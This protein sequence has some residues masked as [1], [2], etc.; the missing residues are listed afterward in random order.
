MFGYNC[1][2]AQCQNDLTG[3]KLLE[4]DH[5]SVIEFLSF[6][7]YLSDQEYWTG[8]V[9]QGSTITASTSGQVLGATR[10]ALSTLGDCVY[11]TD[12]S[13]KFPAP[14]LTNGDCK[15]VKKYICQ[16]YV[17][18]PCAGVLPGA[19]FSQGHC[20]QLNNVLMYWSQAQFT[21][22]TI[23]WNETTNVLKVSQPSL[24]INLNK[25]I[26]MLQ[27]IT[28]MAV[29]VGQ[30]SG[31]G[32][33]QDSVMLNDI[34]LG[35][36]DS[37]HEGNFTWMSDDRPVSIDDW[38]MGEPNDYSTFN[39]EDNVAWRVYE[40]KIQ[41]NDMNGTRSQARALCQKNAMTVTY[42]IVVPDS[43]STSLMTRNQI[44]ITSGEQRVTYLRVTQRFSNETDDV[45]TYD[46]VTSYRQATYSVDN[47]LQMA[48]LSGVFRTLVLL[49][50]TKHVTVMVYFRS[51]NHVASS[52]VFPVQASA[53]GFFVMNP[54]TPSTGNRLTVT[55]LNDDTEVK[56]RFPRN[57]TRPFTVVV[58]ELIFQQ[59]RSL[60]LTL[61]SLQSVQLISDEDF[62]GT[63][64][65]STKSVAVYLGN[66]NSHSISLDSNVDMAIPVDSLTSQYVSFP[67][68]PPLGP[69]QLAKYRF[70]C[71]YDNTNITIYTNQTETIRLSKAGF[72]SDLRLPTDGF[73]FFESESQQPFHVT[74][75]SGSGACVTSLL[76]DTLWK[77]SY[78]VYVA[79]AGQTIHI[80]LPTD[81]R[82]SFTVNGF[83]FDLGYC[84]VIQVEIHGHDIVLIHCLSYPGASLTGC[85]ITLS[86]GLHHLGFRD[87]GVV[88]AAYVS[89]T[90]ASSST[91]FCHALGSVESITNRLPL[92][93]SF[94]ALKYLDLSDDDPFRNPLLP[95]LTTSTA[96]Q[97]T[98]ST[99]AQMTTSA[100]AQMTT[101]S[102]A[103]MTTSVSLSSDVTKTTTRATNSG[104]PATTIAET[105][106]TSSTEAAAS[107]SVV[108]YPLGIPMNLSKDEVDSLLNSIIG[109]LLVHFEDT[110][111]Y[112]MRQN[113]MWDDRPSSK[114]IGFGGVAFLVIWAVTVTSSD[115]FFL[116]RFCIQCVKKSCF[117]RH[118]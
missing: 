57:S 109:Q 85:N 55:A 23:S 90:V 100:A 59:I 94:P 51:A 39:G 106:S 45:T 20:Y 33:F 35:A 18:D 22:L 111:T 112:R 114:V 38:R 110:L 91:E 53:S 7:F 81:Q 80:V 6:R 104:F 2:T 108:C 64:V 54:A 82:P 97:M 71:L 44:I 17:G 56:V 47:G 10:I 30:G 92:H 95:E 89:Q 13:S 93:W 21:A 76:P 9:K 52:L 12:Y 96:A 49:E 79:E 68:G 40:M 14:V 66:S 41:L 102:A 43:G 87:A 105:T 86:Q 88:F 1:N 107:T 46:W 115:I 83:S 24:T 65:Y 4:V 8:A 117:R 70:L 26:L 101:S 103:Q 73:I 84:V 27:N 37:L 50:A 99:A 62:S 31:L 69:S 25:T 78:D 16:L 5:D 58:N 74:R 72:F 15:A 34:M 61:K 113:C 63:F 11:L 3:A 118:S 116:I 48:K 42:L 60:K 36:N 67:S 19:D 75:L 29:S 98:T 28:W 77:S 32:I